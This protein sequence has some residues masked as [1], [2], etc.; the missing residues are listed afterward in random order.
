MQHA[1]V[2]AVVGAAGKMGTR[3]RTRLQEKGHRILCSEQGARGVEALERIGVE[4]RSVAE[5]A[6]AAD[7]VFLAVPD[8]F[9]GSVAKEIIP[10]LRN[11]ATAVLLDP[12]AAYLGQIPQRKGCNVVVTHPCHPTLFRRQDSVEAYHDHFGGITATQD[13]VLALQSGSE[14]ALDETEPLC[15]EV[16][17]PVDTVH[18]ITVEQM[19]LLEPTTV[20]AINGAAIALMKASMDEAVARGVPPAAARAFVLGHLNVIGAVVFG[21]TDFPVSDAA[22]IAMEIGKEYAVKDDW[23]R[24]FEPAEVRKTIVRMLEP[25]A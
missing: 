16:F 20:E 2:I 19:A 8:R 18:R 23:R 21:E 7:Y 17:A 22:A 11:G 24:A 6:S 25:K 5:V 9:I 12:A 15:R 10:N 3:V 4:N 14:S 1:S 13:I